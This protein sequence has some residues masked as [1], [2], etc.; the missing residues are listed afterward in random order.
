MF[1]HFSLGLVLLALFV[2]E[3]AAAQPPP[4]GCPWCTTPTT[5]SE[6]SESTPI[7]GCYNIGMGC[8]EI[9]GSCTYSF[10]LTP[11][12][13]EALN[14]RGIRFVGFDR[15]PLGGWGETI[16]A[17]LDN[18]LLASWN[19]RGVLRGIFARGSDGRLIVLDPAEFAD[20][21]SLVDMVAITSD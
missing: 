16:L 11:A 15:V 10:A 19:C 7:G 2:A 18:G 3:P 1:R 5:C 8:Q 20:R 6:V 14:S 17:E 9:A 13:A 21:Y 12:E 4:H